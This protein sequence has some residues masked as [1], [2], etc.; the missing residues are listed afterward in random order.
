MKSHK[1]KNVPCYFIR[2]KSSHTALVPS[3]MSIIR[4]N[5]G[6]VALSYSSDSLRKLV[7]VGDLSI[8]RV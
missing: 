5:V 3:A 1:V 2:F 6:F 7:K 4:W 8:Q